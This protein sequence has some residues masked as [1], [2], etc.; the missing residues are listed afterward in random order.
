MPQIIVF[1][2][3]PVRSNRTKTDDKLWNSFW[4]RSILA[5]RLAES[6]PHDRKMHV[7]RS[8]YLPYGS[9]VLFLYFS[10]PLLLTDR[11]H[12]VVVY[13]GLNG[14]SAPS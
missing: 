14:S 13:P 6:K 2:N 11:Y 4:G 8:Y 12:N 1:D 7:F 9:F 5:R 10:V 3:G